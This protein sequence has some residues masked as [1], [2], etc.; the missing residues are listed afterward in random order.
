MATSET[1]P[2]APVKLKV[3]EPE[4]E[5]ETDGVLTADEIVFDEEL[6]AKMFANLAAHGLTLKD[7]AG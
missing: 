5:P 7:L 3:H 2:V 4:P 6:I 1:E